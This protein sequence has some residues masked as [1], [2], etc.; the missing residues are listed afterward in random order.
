MTTNLNVGHSPGASAGAASKRRSMMASTVG[1]VLEWYEWSAYAV[2]APFIAKAMFNSDDAVSA[3]LSTLAVFAVGFLMRPLG[4]I[5]FGRIADAKGRKFVLITTMLMMA[6]GSLLIAL[7]PTYGQIGIAASLLLLLARVAQGFAH[8]GES[9]TA[10]TY[11]AEIAPRDKRGQWGSIVFVA[12]FGGSVL[13]YTIGGGVTNVLS[14]SAVAEWGW[15]VP[16]LFGALLALAAL[17]M[18]RGMDES[19]VFNGH[20]EKQVAK[21]TMRLD[22]KRIARS[23]AMMIGMTAGITAAHYT[24]TSYASTYA[25]TRQGMDAEGAYWVTVFAQLIALASLPLWGKLSDKIG[26]RPVLIGFALAM[27]ITQIPLMSMINAQPWTLFVASTL[28]LLIVAA[29]GALLSCVLSEAFPTKIR[30]QGI[31]FAYS[32]S[33]AVFGGTAPYLNALFNSWELG[34]LSNV[35]IMTLC[36]LTGIVVYKLRETKGIDLE[37]A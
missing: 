27:I 37:D 21:A 35:Y 7:M 15:R 31:G 13:A 32:F 29:A 17:Y 25:I 16:F 11:I 6:G 34:W 33:V 1:N 8:G 28:A 36:G 10:N 4:G 22:R 18:R 2:F 14:D 3:L 12:I 19:E 5:V 30:T 20:Q 9:A 24:W 23:I 26:R